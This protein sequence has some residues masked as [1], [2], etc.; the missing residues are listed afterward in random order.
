MSIQ[1]APA[2]HRR[3]DPVAEAIPP[4]VD[5]PDP[6]LLAPARRPEPL[7]TSLQVRVRASTR[8]RFERGRTQA[9]VRTQRPVGVAGQ[10]HRSRA[11][12]LAD[13]TGPL[14]RGRT[15]GVGDGCSF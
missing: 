12:R 15:C 4:R 6:S 11:R 1:R 2:P 8:E 13:D 10:P 5:N 7:N 14:T 3:V 9:A